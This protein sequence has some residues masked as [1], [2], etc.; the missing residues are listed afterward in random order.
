MPKGVQEHSVKRAEYRKDDVEE[1]LK[2]SQ[3]HEHTKACI[4]MV[5]LDGATYQA[6][7]EAHGISRQLVYKRCR[8]VLHRIGVDTRIAAA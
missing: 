3:Y 5:L 1:L 7:S 4:R 2:G 8:E 6:A